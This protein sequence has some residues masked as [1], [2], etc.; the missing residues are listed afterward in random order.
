MRLEKV[1]VGK[2][3]INPTPLRV[4]EIS[5]TEWLER[6]LQFLL[7]HGLLFSLQ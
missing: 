5:Q 7:S 1:L 3:L 2:V 6:Y 4:N